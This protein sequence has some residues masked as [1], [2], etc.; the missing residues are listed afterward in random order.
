M[1]GTETVAITVV[2]IQI[3]DIPMIITD[4]AVAID[5]TKFEIGTVPGTRVIMAVKKPA[6]LRLRVF[7]LVL[8]CFPTAS[9]GSV[10]K[11]RTGLNDSG[12]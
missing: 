8:V 2:V 5:V 10:S 9:A 1:I 4:A 3:M 12:G 11:T 7:E 6:N